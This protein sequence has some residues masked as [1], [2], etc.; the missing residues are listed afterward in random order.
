MNCH[1]GFPPGGSQIPRGID[2]SADCMLHHTLF[3]AEPPQLRISRQLRANPE[4]VTNSS[5]SRPT[6]Q[7]RRAAKQ[8]FAHRFHDHGE[9]KP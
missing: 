9:A 5:T 8:L 3:R 4:S 6:T 7:S 2:D 1:T